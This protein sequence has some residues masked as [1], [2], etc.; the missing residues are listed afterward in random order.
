MKALKTKKDIGNDPRVDSIHREDDGCWDTPA[1]WCYLKPG[2]Q[3]DNNQQHTIHE[4]TIAGICY[5][6][7]YNVTEWANDPELIK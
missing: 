5:K 2:W 4:R 6:L 7:N 1:W 3:V